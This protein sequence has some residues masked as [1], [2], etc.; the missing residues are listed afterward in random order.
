MLIGGLQKV[1]LID[2][3]GKIATT[4]FL[5]GCNFCCPFC[6]SPELVLPEKIKNQPT[7][8][9]AD[10]FNFLK[11]KRGILEGVVI[12]GGEPT[13]SQD[14]LE[15]AKKI[16]KL[17]FLLKLDTNGSN[18]EILEK[19]IR[20]WLLDYVALDIKGPKEKYDFFAGIKVNLSKIEESINLLKEEKIDYEFRTTVAPGLAKED[21]FKIVKWI[22]PAKKYFLQE[23]NFKKE[24][25]DEKIKNL[26]YLQRK[27]IQVI[28]NEIKSKFQTCEMR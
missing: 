23:V 8:S 11:Q 2:Y 15:F 6:Y 4:V 16:K 28:V 9:F 17:G 20:K 25:I 21:I 26:P 10:F 3:P 5:V 19:L 7:I 22:A 13:V 14:L 24:V 12:C 27:D 18:P 1:T